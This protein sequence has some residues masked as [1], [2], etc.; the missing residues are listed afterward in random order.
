MSSTE[1]QA[2]LAMQ[3]TQDRTHIQGPAAALVT[4]CST[5]TASVRGRR[6]PAAASPRTAGLRGPLGTCRDL[7]DDGIRV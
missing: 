3:V 6:Q 2:V 7:F 1:W 4:L 5:A